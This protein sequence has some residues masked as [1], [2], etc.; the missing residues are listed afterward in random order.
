M[1]RLT[2]LQRAK[3][4]I[5]IKFPGIPKNMKTMIHALAKFSSAGEKSL[6]KM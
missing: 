3:A 1:R 4:K 6:N 5:V 2:F